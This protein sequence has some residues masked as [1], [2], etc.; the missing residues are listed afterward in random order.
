MSINIKNQHQEHNTNIWEK[1]WNRRIIQRVPHEHLIRFLAFINC[2]QNAPSLE[3]GFG[4]G[5]ELMAAKKFKLIPTG[6]EVSEVLC[7]SLQAQFDEQKE[8]DITIKIFNPPVLPFDDQSFLVAWSLQAFYYNLDFQEAVRE[9]YRVLRPG[10][11]IFVS[12]MKPDHWYFQYSKKDNSKEVNVVRFTH[13][14]PEQVLRGL[15]L[16]FFNNENELREAFGIFE[17]IEIYSEYHDLFGLK[18]PRWMVIAQKKG[19]GLKWPD[20]KKDYY[21]QIR[22]IKND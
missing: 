3:I 15:R 14:H 19:D 22:K 11:M 12:F 21:S 7:E 17:K 13:E 1:Y 20:L 5:A 8:R 4:A 2:P 16:R 18:S 9:I 10:G 6:V